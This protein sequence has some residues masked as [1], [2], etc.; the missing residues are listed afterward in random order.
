MKALAAVILATAILADAAGTGHVYLDVQ[1]ANTSMHLESIRVLPLSTY[2]LSYERANAE[3]KR[4]GVPGEELAA[5]IPDAVDVV[6]KRTLPPLEKGG[7]P[8]VLENFPS[9]NEQVR[10][11]L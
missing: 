6:P 1:P 9:V 7:N 11:R 8:V 3:R 2:R 10:L 4:V 5:I